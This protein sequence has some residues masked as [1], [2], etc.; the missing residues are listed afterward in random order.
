VLLDK[1][2]LTYVGHATVL[3]ELGGLRLLTDP[4]LSG[5]I[6]HLRRQVPVP[7]I[8][9]LRPLDGILISHAHRDHLDHR[10]LRLLAEDCPLIVPRGCAGRARR[11]GAR[12]VIELD[13]GDR[14]RLRDVVVEAVPAAHSGRR[15]P[16]G[17]ATASLG[18]I[19]EGPYHV[20]FAGDTDL[21][22]GMS[23]L[24]GRVDVAALP[25]WGWGPR[26]P[27]GHL[28]PARAAQAVARIQPQVAVP[29]HWGTL[30][31]WGAQRGLDPLTPARAFAD[32]VKRAAPRT[33]VRILMPGERTS[34]SLLDPGRVDLRGI[35]PRSS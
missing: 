31:A 8:E 32:E 33:A 5:G 18:Y 22:S 7:V 3:I 25:I 28:D 29:I 23:A 17:R 13:E 11:G 10:S 9:D 30:R 16:L 19:L 21:F 1:R 24:A 26:V 34:F 15:H 20:Y 6:L 27:A 12:E 2:G 35:G 4:L 14:L